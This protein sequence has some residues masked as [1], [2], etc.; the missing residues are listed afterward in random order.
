MDLSSHK[1]LEYCSIPLELQDVDGSAAGNLSNLFLVPGTSGKT[2]DNSQ[3][4]ADNS[5]K[6]RVAI[7]G[8]DML[9]KFRTHT[10]IGMAR[11]R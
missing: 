11:L 5:L 1:Q 3:I 9:E 6:S 8:H 4:T 7:C 10:K 2:A